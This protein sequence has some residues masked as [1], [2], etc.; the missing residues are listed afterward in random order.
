MVGWLAGCL[1]VCLFVFCLFACLFVCLA[2][3][4]PVVEEAIARGM[5]AARA[6]NDA[7]EQKR[8]P[9]FAP[10]NSVKMEQ[11]RKHYVKRLNAMLDEIDDEDDEDEEDEENVREL[12][13]HGVREEL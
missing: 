5:L 9:P 8:V 10:Q 11:V 13:K 3:G 1:F 6:V 2:S 4:L 7:L 12:Q